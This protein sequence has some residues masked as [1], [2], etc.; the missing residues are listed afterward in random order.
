MLKEF[1]MHQK[2][3]LRNVESRL[4]VIIFL[5]VSFIIFRFIYVLQN[6]I[7]SDFICNFNIIHSLCALKISFKNNWFSDCLDINNS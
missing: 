6:L 5:L 2:D 4:T 3:Q 7:F 1:V